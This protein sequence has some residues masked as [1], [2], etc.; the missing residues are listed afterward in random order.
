M[1]RSRDKSIDES[2]RLRDLGRYAEALALLNQ[3]KAEH[4]DLGLALEIYRLL[5]RMGRRDQA[6]EGITSALDICSESECD[7][8]AVIYAKWFHCMNTI[9]QTARPSEPMKVL[10]EIYNIYLKTRLVKDYTEDIVGF[11]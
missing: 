10:I 7:S 3:A 9:M 2:H 4:A 11:T 8:S 5:V 1:S 6:C